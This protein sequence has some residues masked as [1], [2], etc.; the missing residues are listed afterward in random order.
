MHKGRPPSVKVLVLSIAQRPLT[1]PSVNADILDVSIYTTG[2][3]RYGR[4]FRN[5]APC[6]TE[7]KSL[8]AA[9][10]CLGA[11]LTNHGSG[12]RF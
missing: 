8:M 1:K 10:E 5:S 12:A 6:L 4:R 3:R 9:D 7:G 2:K 11:T